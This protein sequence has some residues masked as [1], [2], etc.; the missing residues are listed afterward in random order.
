[1]ALI[2]R[3]GFLRTSAVRP[4]QRKNWVIIHPDRDGGTY[5]RYLDSQNS[6]E[7][8][9]HPPGLSCVVE[10]LSEGNTEKEMVR[11]L[12]EYFLAGVQLVW[13]IDPRARTGR[14]CTAEHEWTEIRADA[15]LSSGK[16]LPGFELPLAALFARVAGP[17]SS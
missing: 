3:Y 15:V 6:L 4:L 1:V 8:D 9:K 13:Y 14:A 5:I 2:I 10:I 12:H 16:V 17:Q 11:K 7:P